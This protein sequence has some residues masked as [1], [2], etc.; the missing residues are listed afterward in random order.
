M[1]MQ[2]H[3]YH[4]AVPQPVVHRLRSRADLSEI[5]PTFAALTLDP[6]CPGRYRYRAASRFACRHGLRL[7]PLVPL[8][9]SPEY[10]PIAGYGG[11]KRHYPN[12]PA[13]LL[14]SG[15]LACL[16]AEWQALIAEPIETLSVHMIRTTA[17]GLP[18]PEGRHRDGNDWVGIFVAARHNVTESSGETTVWDRDGE[19]VFRDVVQSGELV[20]FDDRLTTHDASPI[21]A[22]GGAAAWR[23]VLIFSTPD[24]AHYLQDEA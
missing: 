13:S 22:E 23:D 14:R 12:L 17:P 18:V 1:V 10:N 9:Q 5:A 11:V 2:R 16:A 7:L 19:V 4:C 6:Y 24:H 3:Q 8:Y 20:V 21:E 15:A